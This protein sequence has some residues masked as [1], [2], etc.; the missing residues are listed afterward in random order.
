MDLHGTEDAITSGLFTIDIPSDDPAFVGKH[1]YVMSESDLGI[2]T[3]SFEY[4][5]ESWRPHPTS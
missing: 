4:V 1:A 2:R 3:C 5:G